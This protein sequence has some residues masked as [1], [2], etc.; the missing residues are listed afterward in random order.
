MFRTGPPVAVTA[1]SAPRVTGVARRT[2]DGISETAFD[3]ELRRFLTDMLQP[4]GLPLR[5]DLLTEGAGHS[6]GEMAEPLLDQLVSRAEPVDVLVLVFA[7]HDLRLGRATATYLSSVC[8]G[9]PLAFAL[10]DQGSAGAF[11][12]LRMIDEYG[13]TTEGG[14][15]LLLVMEQSAL[16]YQEAAPARIPA[17]HTAVGLRLRTADRPHGRS[18]RQRADVAPGDVATVLAEELAVLGDVPVVVSADL[19]A[20]LPERPDG[21]VVADAGKPFTGIWWEAASGLAGPRTVVADYDPQLRYL[22]LADLE[23]AP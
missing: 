12:G 6:F 9:D 20:L 7:I 22:C 8:P 18:V 19:A 4:Y 17:G 1:P 14:R 10:C 23:F 13:P 2:F 3:P 21:L 15:G 16:H 11:T 5:E